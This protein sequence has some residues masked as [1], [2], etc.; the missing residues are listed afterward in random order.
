MT[1]RPSGRA[2][3]TETR[4][5]GGT[6]V[7]LVDLAREICRRYRDEFPDEQERYGE[8][9]VAW[10]EHDNQWIL[11]WALEDLA[12]IGDLDRHIT[13]LADVLARR[14]FPVPRLVRD[15]EIAADVVAEGGSDALA[16]RLR[17][18]AEAIR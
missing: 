17:A 9:G 7:A 15:L 8:A 5:P 13:W 12:G 14:D 11:H 10:C 18:V 1:E 6:V 2:A 4:L 3:P 16:G